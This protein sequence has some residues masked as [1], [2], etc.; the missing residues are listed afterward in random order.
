MRRAPELHEMTANHKKVRKHA[1]FLGIYFLL[2]CLLIQS[3]IQRLQKW[4]PLATITNTHFCGINL[5]NI[6]LS[7]RQ[8]VM[9]DW[10]NSAYKHNYMISF[11]TLSP[12]SSDINCNGPPTRYVKL[13]VA[14]APGM[15]GTFPRHRGLAISTCIMARAWRTCHDACRDG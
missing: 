4:L 3:H 13:Q 14:H 1:Y 10:Y 15:P 11:D 2:G 5:L 7:R 8:C 6:E 9:L 12:G